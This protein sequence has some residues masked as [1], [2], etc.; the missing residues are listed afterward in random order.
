MANELAKAEFIE[1]QGD[2]V[3][4]ASDLAKAEEQVFTGL[5][6]TEKKAKM[7]LFNA[8]NTAVPIWDELDSNP[9]LVIDCVNII[10]HDTQVAD[11]NDGDKMLDKVRVIFVDKSGRTY[12]SSSEAVFSAV[13]QLMAIFGKP[14]EWEGSLKI[15]PFKQKSSRGATSFL[16]I[17]LV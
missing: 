2:H 13:K 17:K 12:S 15:K 4:S 5:T 9:D 1:V 7:E 3:N 6:L 14:N 10:G 16:S 11:M 8:I